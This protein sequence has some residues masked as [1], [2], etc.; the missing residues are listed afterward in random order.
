MATPFLHYGEFGV[1]AIEPPFAL[2]K[3][4]HPTDLHDGLMARW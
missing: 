1:V 4:G 2:A 3:R